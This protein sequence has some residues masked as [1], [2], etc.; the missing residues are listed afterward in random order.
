MSQVAFH[1]VYPV[2]HPP[3]RNTALFNGETINC[4]QDPK[5]FLKKL[6]Q[7]LVRQTLG[8]ISPNFVCIA[9]SC[10]Q[11]IRYF[12]LPTIYLKLSL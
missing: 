6:L 3:R 9:K 7:T 4:D 5:D 1:F 2:R 11:K 8:S 10:W 12:I